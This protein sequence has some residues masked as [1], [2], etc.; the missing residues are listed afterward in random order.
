MFMSIVL[1]NQPH[2]LNQP[3]NVQAFWGYALYPYNEGDFVKKRMIDCT[4]EEI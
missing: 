4:G 2:F 1:H 3:A